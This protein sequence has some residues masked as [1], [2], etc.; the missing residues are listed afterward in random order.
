MMAYM[1]ASWHSGRF[2]VRLNSLGF[3]SQTWTSHQPCLLGTSYIKGHIYHV[4]VL[5]HIRAMQWINR[6]C[7]CVSWCDIIR[8]K[9][10]ASV[11][12]KT[13]P[14]YVCVSNEFLLL[15]L[16]CFGTRKTYFMHLINLLLRHRHSRYPTF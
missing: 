1:W 16:F 10:A 5:G 2:P 11:Y 8:R 12:I 9:Y 6:S 13:Y 3:Q 14:L 7:R 4:Y 15:F